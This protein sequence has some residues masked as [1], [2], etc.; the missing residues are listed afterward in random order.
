MGGSRFER[1]CEGM[2]RIRM[3]I[4]CAAVLLL[5]AAC[6][7]SAEDMTAE[8]TEQGVDELRPLLE[9]SSV[10]NSEGMSLEEMTSAFSES[11]MSEY[12]DSA[13]GFRMQYPSVFQF[14][15]GSEGLL[16]A[17]AD[18]RATLSIDNMEN[19][20]LLNES[21]LTEAIRMEDP[22][23]VI[24]KNEQNGCLRA[25]HS[26]G[27][28]GPCRT[29]LYFITEKSFHHITLTYPAEEQ[30]AYITYIDYM[31]NTMETDNTDLG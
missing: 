21:I 7:A 18:G 29:D 31:I 14:D 4:I 20:G 15:E 8:E 25:D 17:T 24:R 19:F 27:S 28:G 13:T 3:I 30:D 9:A 12:L 26:T 10:E 5:A 22:Q 2:N 23:A 1:K 11:A 6:P 16:A